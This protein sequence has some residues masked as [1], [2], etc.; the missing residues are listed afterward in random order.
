VNVGNV[1]LV[2]GAW[3]NAYLE[4]LRTFPNGAHDDQVDASSRA[5]AALIK[6]S[7]SWF[8]A[9]SAESAAL[10]LAFAGIRRA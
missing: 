8:D 5:F 3:N 4:E 10:R 7:R 2:K 6:V 9:T 1:A